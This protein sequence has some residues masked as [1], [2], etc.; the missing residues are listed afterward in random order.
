MVS[1]LDS[2]PVGRANL[3]VQKC[4]EQLAR[5]LSQV[6]RTFGHLIHSAEQRDSVGLCWRFFEAHQH[7]IEL[8]GCLLDV[9]HTLHGHTVASTKF[10][11]PLIVAQKDFEENPSICVDRL[12]SLISEH[13][14]TSWNESLPFSV[15]SWS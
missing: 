5:S 15:S 4:E 7:R 8:T 1:D 2:E 9:L 3:H 6:L 10:I 13:Q 12:R 11:A 14:Q